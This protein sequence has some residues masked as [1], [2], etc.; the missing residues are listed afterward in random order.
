MSSD[1]VGNFISYF[2]QSAVD[3]T[4]HFGFSFGFA[5]VCTILINGFIF[6]IEFRT[7]MKRQD[8]QERKYACFA[9]KIQNDHFQVVLRIGVD[10][11]CLSCMHIS[12]CT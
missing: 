7:I 10:I 2:V 1:S 9:G 4:L 11:P 3:C 8:C 12:V 5:S 6:R